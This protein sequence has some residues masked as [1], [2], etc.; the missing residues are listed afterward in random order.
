MKLAFNEISL[1]PFVENKFILYGK[2]EEIL[3]SYQFLNSEFSY[4]HI[5]TPPELSASIVYDD[6]TFIK[7]FSELS[8]PEKNRIQPLFLRKPFTDELLGSDVEKVDKYFFKSEDPMIEDR[9]CKG[10]ATAHLLDIPALSIVTHE[11]WGADKISIY[12]LDDDLEI[13]GAVEVLNVSSRDCR[14]NADLISYSESNYNFVLVECVIRPA[15]KKIKLS[16]DHHGNDK[17]M[18]FAKRMFECKYVVKVIN[19]LP[20]NPTTSRFLRNV[21][22]TG[23]VDITLHW[24]EA[25]YGMSI[26]TTGRNSRE[27][28]EIANILRSKYD[29]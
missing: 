11:I 16:G 17:L 5:V 26:Q 7:W 12:E 14:G 23:I 6:I 8:Q 3:K 22:P 4:N 29:R 2:F 15:L 24:E 19:N 18:A 21:H 27:T 1:Y 13:V 9:Y 28:E 25:G 20:F 10:L